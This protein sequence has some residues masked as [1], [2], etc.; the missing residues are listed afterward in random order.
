LSQAS[1]DAESQ[2]AAPIREMARTGPDWR[3]QS[4]SQLAGHYAA[5]REMEERTAAASSEEPS[6]P[7][8]AGSQGWFRQLLQAIGVF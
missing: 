6:K 2:L 3:G 7:A 5:H 4:C 8:E 1:P